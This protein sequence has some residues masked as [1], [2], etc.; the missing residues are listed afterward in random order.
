MAA[1]LIIVLLNNVLALNLRKTSLNTFH[2]RLH[3]WYAKHGR[4]TLP[5]RNTDDPY[6]IYVSEVMLQ[7]TQVKTVLERYYFP[8]LKR[9]PTLRHLAKAP[10]K[11][12]LQVWQGLGYY[13]RALNLHKAAQLCK[14]GLPASIEE[15]ISLPGIGKNTAHAVAAFAFGQPVAVMEANVKRVC[16]RIFAMTSLNDGELWEKANLLLDTKQSF[17]YNQAMM[18]LGAMVCTKRSPGCRVCPAESICK[19]KASPES[20]PAAKSKKATKVREKKII[21]LRNHKGQYYATARNSR[22]LNGLFHFVEMEPDSAHFT[23]GQKKYSLAK[24]RQLGDI[25]QQYSHFTLEAEVFLLEVGRLQGPDWHS[26]AELAKLPLS[27]AE[28]KI[29]RLLGIGIS[30]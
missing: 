9:F 7:Q 27:M 6:A 11:E 2:T 19:G 30:N 24:A 4:K 26:A 29:L 13:N 20:Y 8:F 28:Q 12:V 22:F 21:V 3:Q 15:L 17:D 23:L 14:T 5:W 10:Q 18:D 25:C 1:E 16:A